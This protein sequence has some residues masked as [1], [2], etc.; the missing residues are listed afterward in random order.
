MVK[1]PVLKTEVYKKIRVQ[2]PSCPFRSLIGKTVA[3]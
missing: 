3:F 2:V 1:A